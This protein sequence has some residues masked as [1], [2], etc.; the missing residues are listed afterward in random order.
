MA[1]QDIGPAQLHS[2]NNWKVSRRLETTCMK[3]K[4]LCNNAKLQAFAISSDLF[5]KV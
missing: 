2:R 3:I 1:E 5:L 4:T